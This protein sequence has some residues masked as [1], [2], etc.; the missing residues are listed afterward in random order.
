[1]KKHNT[2]HQTHKKVELLL[3][4]STKD[5]TRGYWST[6]QGKCWFRC[7]LF[8]PS[9]PTSFSDQ[10]FL[11]LAPVCFLDLSSHFIQPPPLQFSSS[12]FTGLLQSLS[13][14]CLCLWYTPLPNHS[15]RS[16]LFIPLLQ[17]FSG[18]LEDK[19]QATSVLFWLPYPVPLLTLKSIFH[20]F[21]L[22]RFHS[23]QAKNMLYFQC[24]QWLN[25]Q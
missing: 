20:S 11:T 16:T 9:L 8:C 5:R 13:N 6:V 4:I 10:A 21:S 7:N 22:I 15:H 14:R 3:Y 24:P 23:L 19:V 1:M 12:S 17:L 2:Q 25:R 18:S